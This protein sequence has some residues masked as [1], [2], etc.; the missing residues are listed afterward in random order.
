MGNNKINIEKQEREENLL[1]AKLYI[2]Y[3]KPILKIIDRYRFY[4]NDGI[5]DI[6]GDVILHICEK[7]KKHLY[8]KKDLA[9]FKSWVYCVTTN[10]LISKYCRSKRNVRIVDEGRLDF[11]QA[12]SMEGCS[13]NPQERECKLNALEA[14]RQSLPESQAMLIDLR[15]Y[16]KLTYKEIAEIRSLPLTT[17]ASQIKTIYAFLRKQMK[18]KGYVDSYI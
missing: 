18:K 1:M 12:Y 11:I 6:L 9:S 10:Y 4:T 2:E 8:K 17:V 14:L 15:V 3:K 7:V 16:Q 5:D 13:L